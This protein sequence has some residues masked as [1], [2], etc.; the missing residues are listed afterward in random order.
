LNLP[1][2]LISLKDQKKMIIK[3]KYII[4]EIHI[5]YEVLRTETIEGSIFVEV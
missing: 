5:P 1:K 3:Q 4:K 2:G